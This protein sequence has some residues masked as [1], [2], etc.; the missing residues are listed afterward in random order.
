MRKIL[1]TSLAFLILLIGLAVA[2]IM[3]KSRPAIEPIPVTIAPP[4]VRSMTIKL[5]DIRMIVRS[6]GS[7][8]PHIESNLISQVAGQIIS[9]SPNFAAGGFFDENEILLKIDPRDYEFAIAR[10][11][12]EFSRSR[13]L[14]SIEEEEAALARQEWEQIGHGENPNPL[15]V[16]EPQLA[17]ARSLATAA[18]ASLDQARLNL[19]RTIIRAPYTGRIREKFVD[20][21]QYVSPGNQLAGMYAVDFAEI[22]LPVADD[23]LAFLDIC[24]DTMGQ[25]AGCPNLPVVMKSRFAGQNYQW[26]GMIVRVE[27]ELDPKTR[28]LNLICRVD[29]PYGRKISDNRPPLAVGMFVE[30]Q[31]IGHTAH[32][33]AV[34]E[35]SALRGENQVLVIDDKNRLHYR[36]VEI[37][38]LDF[39]QAIISSG[40]SAG[41]RIC[42]SPV[43]VVV[44]GMHVRIAEEKTDEQNPPGSGDH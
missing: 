33:V 35:R 6:Q 29:D 19:S 37:L 20:V 8:I 28:M 31:I 36:Q 38:R 30:A 14:L 17:E 13:L 11:Q 27:S 44:D 42:L 23:Q 22:R 12:A 9:T 24:L 25:S 41:E 4:L 32:N 16:R 5:D 18:L 40:L 21:G 1:R 10:F 34:I 26:Q 7:V 3:I 39:Q 43:A 2:F 15:V